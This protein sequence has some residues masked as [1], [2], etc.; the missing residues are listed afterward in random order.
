MAMKL[1]EVELPADEAPKFATADRPPFAVAEVPPVPDPPTRPSPW[2]PDMEAA[3]RT[4]KIILVTDDLSAES[5]IR[6]VFYTALG[7]SRPWSKPKKGWLS[8]DTRKW[9]EFEPVGWGY[10]G[11]SA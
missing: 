10:P 5:G 7:S 3:D 8:V 11:A 9:V 6:A 2:N 1:K 4:G